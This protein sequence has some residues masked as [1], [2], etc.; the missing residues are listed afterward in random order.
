MDHY[1]K[2]VTK[3]KTL[4]TCVLED[5][6]VV[7]YDMNTKIML[8]FTNR[9]VKKFPSNVWYDWN[10]EPSKI[11]ELLF[12]ALRGATDK[13]CTAL[14]KLEKFMGVP[15]LL[16]DIYEPQELPSDCP[17][18]F[19]QWIRENERSL[20]EKA[21][22]EYLILKREE[23]LPKESK[24][25][26]ELL[27]GEG[28]P[29]Q[30]S[31][32]FVNLYCNL[33]E[34]QRNSFNQILKTSIK[35]TSWNLGYD[36]RQFVRLAIQGQPV[37][38]EGAFNSYI[39]TAGNWEDVVDTNRS[40]KYNS[41]LLIS[42]AENEK[43]VTLIRREDTIRSITELKSNRF[44][45]VVPKNVQ[46]FTD[47]GKMQNNCVGYYYHDS[48]RK[49]TN[50]IYFIRK[51]KNPEH[52]YITCRFNVSDGQT[53]EAR[54]VNNNDVDSKTAQNFIKE[55]DK[56]IREILEIE[57]TKKNTDYKYVF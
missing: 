27:I 39:Y 47:E 36:I 11:E 51:A 13:Q 16:E 12:M 10:S 50:L 42:I 19:I 26:V 56:K 43:D 46:D 31:I 54:T 37:T 8:S 15:D 5:G 21:L 4:I 22:K 57:E 9:T 7:N 29:Y 44:T 18:G 30:N 33:T 52:S 38:G 17:K 23:T 2:T 3:D 55:I 20:S 25:V 41:K 1:V 35:G 32:D 40:F 28:A 6:G 53:V 48:I 49:G 24:E 45:I 14:E 34:K